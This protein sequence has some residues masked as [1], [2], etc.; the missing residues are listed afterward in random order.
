MT[1]RLAGKTAS[2][3]LGRRRL[4]LGGAV[5]VAALLFWQRDRLSPRRAPSEEDSL[6]GAP[7][8]SANP[9]PA[10]SLVGDGPKPRFVD[11][12]N[13]GAG[14]DG[15]GAT[16]REIAEK[17]L[18]RARHTLDGYLQS[19]R[20][21][22]GARP[23]SEKPDLQKPHSVQPSTQPLARPDHKLTDAR[24]TLSQD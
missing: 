5:L 1:K 4:A 23:L 19:T 12:T 2:S 16:T 24:V 15:A 9:D 6:A 22:P 17:R 8:R 20:Y 10:R 21:P 13:A 7:A 18:A 3:G 11:P 14:E